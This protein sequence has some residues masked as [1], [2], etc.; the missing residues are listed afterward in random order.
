[1]KETDISKANLNGE[2][3]YILKRISSVVPWLSLVS[4]SFKFL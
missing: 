4:L 2:L 3:G 1:M